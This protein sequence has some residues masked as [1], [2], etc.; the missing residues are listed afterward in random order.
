MRAND[1]LKKFEPF[2]G[3]VVLKVTKIALLVSFS[4]TVIAVFAFQIRDQFIA[5]A[6]FVSGALLGVISLRESFQ[7][8][9]ERARRLKEVIEERRQN[10]NRA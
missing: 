2:Q 4:Y 6:G 10:E 1:P 5:I 8:T 7:H 3:G 9:N